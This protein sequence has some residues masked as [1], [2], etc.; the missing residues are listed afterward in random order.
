MVKKNLH[1]IIIS[2][3]LIFIPTVFGLVFWSKLPESMTSH[4]GFNGNPDG[5]SSKAFCVFGIPLIMLA[6]HLV[7]IFVTAFDKKNKDQNQK[8][9]R[10]IFYIVPVISLYSFSI[11]YS[12]A[13]GYEFET[14]KLTLILIGAMF[15]IFGNF[16]PKCKQ[17]STLGIKLPW[18]LT[19]EENWNKTHRLGGKLWVASGIAMLLS[20]FLPMKAM[21]VSII[22]VL[23]VAAV[24]PTV[25]SYSLYK[26]AVS[27]G[28]PVLKINSRDKTM[29]IIVTLVII[30]LFICA[31]IFGDSGSIEYNFNDTSFDITASYWQDISINYSDVDSVEFLEVCDAG[32]RTNG[33]GG[34]KILLG[35]FEN[36]GF[37]AYTRYT[38]SSCESCILIVI[39]GNEL[40]INGETIEETE[41]IFKTISDKV[42]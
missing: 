27:N 42:Q 24:V 31:F 33:F 4:W 6:F 10:L 30:I 39:D 26:K 15:L 8:M 20:V 25:Y 13:F 19:N 11:I 12:V 40:V 35:E 17:N 18:T 37:G 41:K 7:C 34:T 32:I 36:D 28:D 23:L 38:Y 9:F 22:I 16:L 2:S 21:V 3:I 5:F 1:H 29:M 14:S